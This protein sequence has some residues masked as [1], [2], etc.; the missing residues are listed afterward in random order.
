MTTSIEIIPST[1][2]SDRRDSFIELNGRER[3][4]TLFDVGSW[5]ELL[6]PFDRIES[7]WLLPQNVT[8]QAD[9]GCIVLKGKIDG[10]S[11]VVISMEPAF[12]GGS[13][14]EVSGAKICAALD[15]ACRDNEN[16]IRTN[17]VLLL[18]TG[19]VR[20]T[21]ANLGLAAVAE[22]ISSLLSLRKLVPIVCLTAGT[23]GCFGGM[24]L[25]AALSSYMV[26]TVEGRLGLN[27]PEVIEQEQGAE[28]F[29]SKDRKLI[30]AIDGGEQRYA[31]GL[32]DALVKDDVDEIKQAVQSLLKAGVPS[33]FR[34]AQVDL[35]RK[36]IAA[37]DPTEQ[38]NPADLRKNWHRENINESR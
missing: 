3:A 37:L 1:H 4:I 16:G 26:M 5:R 17:A 9:D 22:I 7:P 13:L 18:E 27:G 21:E 29:D 8:P 24:S 33:V 23:V 12:Q 36:R 19:G 32:A 11:T 28:E 6:G 35:Y 15:L 34:S 31:T 30:W 20:L 38:W 10:V 2:K 14:G 25:V